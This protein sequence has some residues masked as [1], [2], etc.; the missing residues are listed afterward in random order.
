MENEEKEIKSEWRQ[1][2]LPVEL[3]KKLDAERKWKKE[4]YYSIIDRLVGGKAE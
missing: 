1:V 4:P 2:R 3:V